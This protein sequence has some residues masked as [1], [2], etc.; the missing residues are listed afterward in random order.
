MKKFEIT[1]EQLQTIEPYYSA[2]KEWFPDAFKK[3]FTGWA[4]DIL[5]SNEKWIA[6]FE[7]D[8]F[9]YGIGAG[10]KWFDS[11][12]E[13]HL[14][15]FS[16]QKHKREATPQE[17]EDALICEAEKRGLL[18]GSYYVS[19]KVYKSI[20]KYPLELS[21]NILSDADGNYI[22]ES[23]KWATIIETITKEEAEKILNKKI[24]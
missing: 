14:F 3:E 10:G 12:N 18:D 22:F 20:V 13:I 2:V 8:I 11:K 5:Q 19:P 21:N 6:Y 9:R 24:V 4:K 17:V 16:D 15:K 1:K 7:N 23:G